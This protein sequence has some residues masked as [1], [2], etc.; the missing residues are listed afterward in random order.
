MSQDQ[1]Y[2]FLAK[3]QNRGRWFTA[4]QITVGLNK[5]KDTKNLRASSIQK[6]AKK[7]VHWGEVIVNELKRTVKYMVK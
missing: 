6:S 2:K 7:C 4:K 1:V 5:L 3:K